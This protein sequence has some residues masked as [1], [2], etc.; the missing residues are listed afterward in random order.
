MKIKK[1]VQTATESL[2]LTKLRKFQIEP[3]NNIL[4]HRDALVIAPT[5]AG[6][7]AIY[8]IPAVINSKKGKWTLVIE[9]T[10][11]LIADQVNGL[12]GL[13][14]AAEMM[15]NRNHNK[16]DD[17]LAKIRM[18]EIAMLYVTPERLKT[19]AFQSAVEDNP[20]WLLVVDEVHCV[21]DWGFTF[22]SAYLQIKSFIKDLDQRPVIAAFTATAPPE[23]QAAI[24]KL[25]GM[26]KAD[27]YTLSLVR[28]N[29]ILLKED[30]SDLGMDKPKKD[31]LGLIMKK[32]LSRVNYNIKK[33]GKD[34]RVVVYCAT[35]KNVD[36]VYNYLSR[37]FKKEVVKCHAYMDSDKR[38]KHEL[39]FINGSKRIMVA[40]TAFGM[41]IDVPDIR[42]VIHFNL[43][44]STI[45]YYQQIGR[46]G[47]DGEKSHA[48]LLYHSDDIDLNQNILKK[49]DLSSKVQAWLSDR[50]YEMVSLPE[51]DR[52]MMQQLL[53]SLG[54]DH[55]ATCRHC[56]NCQKARR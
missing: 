5:S 42:L 11:A 56:T 34:G 21:L 22:R 15:T 18:G 33:Y 19:T 3:I 12:Q 35:R 54:E 48:V 38:E 40:T 36:V 10:I 1:L 41:G 8:Q 55:P 13:G 52:C 16:H 47:R 24:S 50:L 53:E 44:L 4:D 2:G 28:D 17:I 32:R 9:P 51:S 46:A 37:K 20:P 23:Y 31:R 14:I 26:K 45:D 30:Y 7:S 6:K 25:L 43:P 39:Q 49:K 29:I 27:T